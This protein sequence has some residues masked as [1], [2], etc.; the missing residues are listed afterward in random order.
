MTREEI[1]DMRNLLISQLRLAEEEVRRTNRQIDE[2]KQDCPHP[3]W[4]VQGFSLYERCV[5]CGLGWEIEY[6]VDYQTG[7]EVALPNPFKKA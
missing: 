6:K 2:L 1:R 4:H 7:R 5:D 3:E